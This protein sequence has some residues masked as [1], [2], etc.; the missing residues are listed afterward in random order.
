MVSYI[1]KLRLQNLR[2]CISVVYVVGITLSGSPAM[3]QKAVPP[4]PVKPPNI[5]LLHSLAG[6]DETNYVRLVNV[7][8]LR[9]GPQPAIEVF[10][11]IRKGKKYQRVNFQ[12][13]HRIAARPDFD[14]W[15]PMPKLKIGSYEVRLTLAYKA[16]ATANL[17]VTGSG[18]TQ[19]KILYADA[20]LDYYAAGAW[21]YKKEP[22]GMLASKIEPQPVDL[23]LVLG[24]PGDGPFDPLKNPAVEL[25][26]LPKDSSITVGFSEAFIVDGPGPDILIQPIAANSSAGELAKVE[27]S[28]GIGKFS[29]VGT[30]KGAGPQ[31]IDL[32][33]F[34]LGGSYF[35]VRITGLDTGGRI[36]GFDLVAVGALNYEAPQ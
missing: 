11:R 34:E 8:T 4:A 26:G 3:A 2:K 23:E 14:R 19:R 27:V 21:P 17:E 18:K 9:T 5:F 29:S 7:P 12:Y 1:P 24:D 28:E 25:L 10:K 31:L 33:N 15:Y 6:T 36:P 20:V 35:A 22:Y 13:L 16:L 30:I 32:K